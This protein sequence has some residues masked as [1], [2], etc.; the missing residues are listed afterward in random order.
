MS[1]FD[2]P[3]FTTNLGSTTKQQAV[4]R[5]PSHH[6]RW[7]ST[8]MNNINVSLQGKSGSDGSTGSCASGSG[9]SADGLWKTEI[10]NK[11]MNKNMN[12]GENNINTN[13][14]SNHRRSNSLADVLGMKRRDSMAELLNMDAISGDDDDDDEEEEEEEEE[15]SF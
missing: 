2:I 14:R 1:L 7:K 12:N 8:T 5:R 15:F 6:R 11:N 4:K 3:D 10:G 9:G 13:V